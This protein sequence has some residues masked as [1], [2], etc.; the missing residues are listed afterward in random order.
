[1]GAAKDGEVGEGQKLLD[2]SSYLYRVDS[3]RW[4]IIISYRTREKDIAVTEVF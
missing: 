1:V 4:S 2:K 3:V